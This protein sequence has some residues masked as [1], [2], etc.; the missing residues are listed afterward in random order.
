MTRSGAPR[1]LRVL[2]PA[3]LILAW[4]AA[5]SVGGPYFGRISEVSS[6]DQASYLPASAE[7]TKVSELQPEFASGDD[8]PA[9]V[10]F[11][12]DGGLT[13]DDRDAITGFS[14][15]LVDV[16]GV[17]DDVSPP[18]ESEDGAAIELFVPIAG[19]VDETVEALRD[20]AAASATAGLVAYVTGPAGFTADLVAGFAGIDGLLLIVALIAV[21]VILLIVYRS[22]LLPFLVLGTAVFSLAASILAVWWLAYAGVVQINGQ[23]QGILFILVIG[24]ATDYSLLYVSRYREALRDAES[25][26]DATRAAVRGS[27]EPILA[28]GGTVIVG[29]LCL[30]FSDLNSNKALGPVAA[31]GIGFALLGALTLLPAL[32]MATGRV[33]FWPLRPTYG[34]A[35]PVLVGADARGIWPRVGRLVSRHARLVWVVSTVVLLAGAVGVTQLKADGVPQSDLVLGESQ[36]RDGQVALGEHFPGGSGSPALIVGPEAQIDE[37]ADAALT[38]DGVDSVAAVSENSPTG[39]MPVGSDAEPFP[40][41]TPVALE[42]TVVDGQ[43]MIQATL[44][45]A[46]DSSAAEDAVIGLRDAVQQV[47]PDAIVGGVTATALDTT[48]TSIRDRTVIIPIVLVV[49]LLILM[50]L[51]R[52]ILAP[53]LLLIS[54]V[55]SFATALGVSALVFNGVLGF[56][57]ADPAVPLY[58][59]VFLVALSIDYNIFLMTR[60]REESLVHGT[61]QG[62]L[63]GLSV[64]GGV[65]TSAGVVL[66]ATFAALG[67]IPILFLAQIAFIVAFGVLLD[68]IIVRSLLVPALA[69]DIGRAIWWPSKL[70]R[71]DAG[72]RG[73]H[74]ATAPVDAVAHGQH[75][76]PTVEAPPA[77]NHARD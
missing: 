33:A 65:I 39:T 73:A 67:V 15:G 56:P 47:A 41:P 61:R 63:R 58:A 21:F 49:I 72:H 18:I 34:S 76:A 53:V 51:L 35:H 54:V 19:E 20:A 28:S 22:P 70:W 12:R 13:D 23:V 10:L 46:A 29:L 62:I 24:A 11:V 38:V 40:F 64:T 6:N 27:I 36:A 26:W 68:T 1:P 71:D 77:G 42:P 7:A 44:S 16:E 74:A 2:I 66:A 5:A 14:D 4:L 55:V 45:S 37:L 31:I 43:V 69:Y 8:I 17:G 75:A 9:I 3:L 25:R 60:V 30:L 32:L 52:S 57:G 50:M 48:T 59:F